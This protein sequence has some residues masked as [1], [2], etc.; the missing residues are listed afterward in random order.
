MCLYFFSRYDK[1]RDLFSSLST[2]HDLVIKN[3]GGGVSDS[4]T[5]LFCLVLAP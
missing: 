4:K 2:V 3:E 5:A 1:R